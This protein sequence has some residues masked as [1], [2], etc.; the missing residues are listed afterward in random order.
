MA[1]TIFAFCARRDA[2]P[3]LGQRPG[4]GR[5]WGVVFVQSERAK[6]EWTF[7]LGKIGLKREMK[8]SCSRRGVH[9]PTQIKRN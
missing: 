4:F 1:V 9:C 2:R 7:C 3:P 5:H 6:E 8:P